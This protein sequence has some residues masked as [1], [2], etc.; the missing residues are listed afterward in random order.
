MC[1]LILFLFLLLLLSRE[2]GVDLR[3]AFERKL[4]VLETRY[5]VEKARGRNAKWTEYQS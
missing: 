5:P 4:A 2:C 3:Q 1:Y